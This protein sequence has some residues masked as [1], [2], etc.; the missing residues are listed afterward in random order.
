MRKIRCQ[1]SFSSLFGFNNFSWEEQRNLGTPLPAGRTLQPSRQIHI[2]FES[3]RFSQP[4][5]MLPLESP[6]TILKVILHHLF[7]IKYLPDGTNSKVLTITT[8]MFRMK[9]QS[10]MSRYIAQNFITLL[11]GTYWDNIFKQTLQDNECFMHAIN[12]P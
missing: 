9:F 5:R 6:S 8:F 7:T 3:K 4:L 2:H 11:T 1:Y 12:V 10:P